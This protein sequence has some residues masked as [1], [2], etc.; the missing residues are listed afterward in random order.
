MDVVT[1]P[2][3]AMG[4][5]QG[6]PQGILFVV[7]CSGAATAAYELA[8]GL[9]LAEASWAAISAVI[10]SQEPLHDSRLSLSG[11]T[12]G[13]LVGI[14]ATILVSCIGSLVGAPVGAQMAV[15]VALAALIA[16][17]YPHLR[18]A[19]WTC[20]TLL[21]AC[22]PTVPIDA[23]ALRRGYEVILGAIIGW[24]FHRGAEIALDCLSQENLP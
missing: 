13:T 2:P 12:V 1:N 9:R 15:A 6:I 4:R 5:P 21:L 24:T 19:M 17:R 18:V 20:P 23:I 14:A 16:R 11:R 7:R 10:V 3:A 8:A 22:G